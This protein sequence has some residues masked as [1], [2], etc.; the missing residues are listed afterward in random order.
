M[1]T[2]KKKQ[3]KSPVLVKVGDLVGLTLGGGAC[4]TADNGAYYY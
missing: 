4:D 1:N 3:Y 2:A